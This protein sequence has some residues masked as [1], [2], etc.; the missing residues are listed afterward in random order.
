MCVA[1]ILGDLR[2]FNESSNKLYRFFVKMLYL[3]I[4]WNEEN[5]LFSVYFKLPFWDSLSRKLS[6]ICSFASIVPDMF[7]GSVRINTV[8]AS[9]ENLSPVFLAVTL[10]TLTT[11]DL[12][13]GS[14]KIRLDL[15]SACSLGE[16]STISSLLVDCPRSMIDTS[17]KTPLYSFRD[18][19]FE[20]TLHQLRTRM[21]RSREQKFGQSN[22]GISCYYAS[23]S[24]PA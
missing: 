24:I 19:F 11:G 14:K 10:R 23:I 17:W 15:W 22:T 16:T 6:R 21:S 4:W 8:I 13:Q 20:L 18:T 12:Q 2:W 9:I 1:F 3:S 7:M 5:F